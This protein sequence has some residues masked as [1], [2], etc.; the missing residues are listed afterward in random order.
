[1]KVRIEKQSSQTSKK[2]VRKWMPS[3]KA[4]YYFRAV[5]MIQKRIFQQL[6]LVK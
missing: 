1:M 4:K 3:K 6:S 5:K 2:F